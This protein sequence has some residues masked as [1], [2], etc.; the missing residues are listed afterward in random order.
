MSKILVVE[1]DLDINKALTCRLRAA[2]YHVIPAQDGLVGLCAA[3][4]EEPDVL[5]I[6]ISMPGGDGFSVVERLREN[7]EF[8]DVPFIV[9]TASRRPEYRETA[10]KLGAVAYL[11]K[12]YESS[13][14]LGAVEKAVEAGKALKAS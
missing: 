5:V 2:G 14:L 1:D 10:K 6:D 12:P 9:L 7:T 8:G 3:V 4:R 13:E 11:E